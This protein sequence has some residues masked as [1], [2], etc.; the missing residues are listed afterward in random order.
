MPEMAKPAISRR[1]P[2]KPTKA[3]AWQS[4]DGPDFLFVFREGEGGNVWAA[5]RL[6]L[7][8]TIRFH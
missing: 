1:V 4:S 2:Q 3:M 7:G 6:E 5:S 8:G